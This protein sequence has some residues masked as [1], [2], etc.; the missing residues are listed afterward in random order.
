MKHGVIIFRLAA[1]MAG[2]K[3]L[4]AALLEKPS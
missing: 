4:A 1:E 2:G 3:Y